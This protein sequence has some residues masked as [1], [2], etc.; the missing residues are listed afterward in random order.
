VYADKFLPGVYH[1]FHRRKPIMLAETA[2][3][4]QGGSKAKWITRVAGQIKSRY[5]A[6]AAF[7][8]FNGSDEFQ[9]DITWAVTSSQ[10]AMSAFR[11]MGHMTYYKSKP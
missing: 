6:V 11:K 5:P 9:S 3:V 2:S 7:V 4:E 1:D 10:S 8:Y